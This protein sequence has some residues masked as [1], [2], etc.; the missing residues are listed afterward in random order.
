MASKA[1]RGSD[2]RRRLPPGQTERWAVED[3]RLLDHHIEEILA[4]LSDAARM[5][6]RD[7]DVGEHPVD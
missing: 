1:E 6:E 3:D 4:S 7:P 5:H 2:G